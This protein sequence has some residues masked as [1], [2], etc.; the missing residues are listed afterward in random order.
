MTIFA[1]KGIDLS[2]PTIEAIRRSQAIIEFDPE[3]IILNANDNFLNAMGYRLEEIVGKHHRIFVESGFSLSNEYKEF[4]LKL[5]EGNFQTAEYKRIGKNGKE[6]WIQGSYNPVRDKNGNIVKIVKFA[7]DV[8][9]SKK[10]IADY[11]GT[12]EAVSKTRAIISFTMDGIIIDANESFLQALGYTLDEVKGK[13]HNIFVDPA[14]RDSESYRRFWDDLKAGKYKVAEYKRIGKAGNEVWISASYNPILDLNGNPF[15][16][17]KFATDV[18]EQKLRAADNQG[19]IDAINK[20]QAVIHFNTDGTIL[21]AND[22]FLSTMGYRSDE[23]IGK[24]HRMFV[25]PNEAR[26]PEYFGFWPM[27]AKGQSVSKVFKRIAKSGKEVWLQASYTPIYDYAGRVFKIVKY[28]TDITDIIVNMDSTQHAIQNVAAASEELSNSIADIAKNIELSRQSTEDIIRKAA[29][30][31]KSSDSLVNTTQSMEH[32]V[33]LI[34]KIAG[35][36]NLLALNATIEAARAG[37]AGK[38]FAVVA[39]EVKNLAHQTASATDEI[40][41]E[42]AKV[43]QITEEVAL[44]IH[45]TVKSAHE[46][47]QYV[48][49]VS[50]SIQ[51]QTSAT[52]AI[53]SSAQKTLHAITLISE[54]IRKVQ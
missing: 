51:H 24:H 26:S 33:A 36:V 14:E 11:T 8:T 44:S 2:K 43:Q 32:I 3:G 27:L 28:A 10:D 13:H 34:R 16:I 49:S 31:G 7:T 25:E 41:R 45:D 20:V 37:E 19:Q 22:A 29:I 12:L 42:I 40:A 5:K 35:Q 15:K 21:L 18:T 1:K 53:A 54:K 17:I 52:S 6:V 50:D 38:G 46:V 23:V 9:K 47:G 39:S 4:W 48:T 30:S